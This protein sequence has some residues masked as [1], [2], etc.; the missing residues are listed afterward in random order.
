MAA[1]VL[2]SWREGGPDIRLGPPLAVWSLAQLVERS[3]EDRDVRVRVLA[4]PL[5]VCAGSS[6]L[7]CSRLA[8]LE[9]RRIVNP[10]GGRF[11]SCGGSFT[12]LAQL[13]EQRP[14]KSRVD[15]SSPSGGT[16]GSAT[17]DSA[18]PPLRGC[19]CVDGLVAKTPDSKSGRP[20]FESWSA[21]YDPSSS[22]GW[23]G[24]GFSGV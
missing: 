19:A 5:A 23:D 20:R 15:G 16:Q 7:R 22:P 3:A 18:L 2:W 13:V 1:T 12:P 11:E 6:A 9:E 8:Q 21:C 10:G 24:G 14:F 4:L 17:A